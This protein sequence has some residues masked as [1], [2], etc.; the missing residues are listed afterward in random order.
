M[1]ASDCGEAQLK[2]PYV[3]DTFVPP[4]LHPAKIASSGTKLIFVN[5]GATHSFFSMS[6]LALPI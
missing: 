6:V 1:Q 2:L 3:V 5:T 4:T